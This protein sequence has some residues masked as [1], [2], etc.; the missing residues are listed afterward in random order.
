M[1]N[2]IYVKQPDSQD[3][4]RLMDKKLAVKRPEN[5]PADSQKVGRQIARKLA[6]NK[7]GSALLV[8]VIWYALA[9]APVLR[10]PAANGGGMVLVGLASG[11]KKLA[12][13]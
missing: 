4:D 10:C 6:P 3:I 11:A 12:V 13:R 8:S 5:W 1:P 7:I 2:R 9:L